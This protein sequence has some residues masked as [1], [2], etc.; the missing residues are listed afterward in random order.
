MAVTAL[1]I[2]Q[3]AIRLGYAAC[4]IAGA[5]Y[6]ADY[7]GALDELI[8]LFPDLA[9]LYTPM[10][11]RADPRIRNPWARS[12]VVCIR[13]Y[14]KYRLPAGAVGHIGRNYLADRRHE[15]CP[16]HRIHKEM[17]K[18]LKGLGFKV[19]V[20]TVPDRRA[21]VRAGLVR[22]G[23]NSF[24][25]S[26]EYGSWINIETWLVD[27]DLAI[28]TS[29]AED[30]CPPG[31]RACM[32]ACPTG[33]I[34]KP[35]MVRMDRCVAYLTYGAPEPIAPE[36]WKKMGGWIYGCDVCQQMCPLNKRKWEEREEM[37]WMQ[38]AE[39]WLNPEALAGMD[40]QIYLGVIHPRFWYIPESD[41]ARWRANAK[42]AVEAGR[43]PG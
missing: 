9:P 7:A 12:I 13:R 23:R 30:P 8:A 38:A 20:G 15:D 10:K 14:G 37:P 16:D 34:V 42:R 24:A 6:F 17:T 33:A 19:K 36:L 18:Y 28:D 39:Q 29:T 21:A 35:H 43:T 11:V 27:A 41:L 5:E 25:Y 22:I 40:E 32:D 3:E 2:K 26:P 4:G 1:A 31:C